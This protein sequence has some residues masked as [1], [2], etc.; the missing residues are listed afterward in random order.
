M[1]IIGGTISE[2]IKIVDSKF[3]I[4][5]AGEDKELKNRLNYA[6][7]YTKL[8][9]TVSVSLIILIVFGISFFKVNDPN[10]KQI[11]AGFI[12]TVVGYWLK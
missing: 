10:V 6:K 2:A 5:D 4:I 1:K 9:M 7:E 3:S 11:S 8:I 12:G